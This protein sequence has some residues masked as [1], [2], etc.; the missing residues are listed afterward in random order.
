MDLKRLSDY[1][2][3]LGMLRR[4]KHE[5][6]RLAGIEHPESVAEHSLRAAQIAFA[7]AVLERH[8]NPPAVAAISLFHDV[9]ECRVG[10]VHRVASRYVEADKEQAVRDQCAALG[11]VGEAILRLWLQ[12]ERQD[13]AAG[14]IAKDADYLEMAAMAR[15]FQ[16]QGHAATQDWLNNISKALKT[17]SAQ[18]LFRELAEG[19]PCDWWQGLKKIPKRH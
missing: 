15:E 14:V 2:F 17:E 3:E 6:W 18:K 9:E 10:D 11:P 8:P 5:G 13:T 12:D 4:V 16:E 7:L 1:I 19:D